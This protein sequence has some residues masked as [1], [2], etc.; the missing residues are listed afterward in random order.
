MK[1]NKLY[2]KGLFLSFIIL[3]SS[4]LITSVGYSKGLFVSYFTDIRVLIYNFIP[5][6]ALIIIL[7]FVLRNL[8]LSFLIVSI[9]VN[10]GSYVNYIKIIYR[11]EPFLA[12]DIKLFSEAFAMSKKYSLNLT[13]AN[14]IIFVFSVVLSMYI[15]KIMKNDEIVYEN[16][17]KNIVAVIAVFAVFIFGFI[18]N[19]DSYH[20][21]GAKSGLSMWTEPESY[22]SKGF[23]YPFIYSIKYSREYKYPNYNKKIAEEIYNSY[24]DKNIPEDKKVNVIGIMLESFKDFSVYQSEGLVFEKD[25][26]RYF[27]KLQSEA[28]SGNILVNTF[29]GGT[30][31]TESNFLSGYR[32][33]PSFSRPVMTYPRYFKDQGYE[34]CAFHPNVGSFY[35]R[36]H[37][38]PNMG[39]DQFYEY[40]NTFKDLNDQILSDNDFFNFILEKYNEDEARKDFYFAVTYQNHGPYP[41]TDISPEETYIKWN[42]KYDREWYN[43]FNHYL[44]GISFTSESLKILTDNLR[45]S[46]KPTVLILFGDHC[47]SMGDNKICFDMFDVNYDGDTTEGIKNLYSTPYIVW[48]N[49]SAKRQIGRDFIGQGKDLEPAF[50][51][52]EVLNYMGIEGNQYNQFLTDFTKDFTVAKVHWFCVGGEYKEELNEYEKKELDKFKNVEYYTSHLLDRKR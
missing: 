44:N 28:I 18:F 48:A 17:F 41:K 38:Y 13:S 30:F 4:L 11:E 51:M 26:Y 32:D 49:K 6:Y 46:K 23:V 7:A 8:R 45:Y 22:Q 50:L 52:N 36:N 12:R 10:I 29:G 16:V 34:T 37:A 42:D 43:Y 2:I 27:H 20:V 5:I 25:P 40:D 33:C 47:P 14:F 9:I 39:F 24:E 15:F 3:V 1:N 19:Y 21:I 31:V 35:N